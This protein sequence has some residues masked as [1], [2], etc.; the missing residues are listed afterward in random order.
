LEFG[1]VV[2]GVGD[3]EVAEGVDGVFPGGVGGGVAREVEDGVNEVFA[4][5]G[6]AEAG[7]SAVLGVDL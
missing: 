6:D 1:V 5:V 4:G 3:D 7:A 2:G